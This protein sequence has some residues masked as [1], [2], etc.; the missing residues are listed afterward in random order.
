MR[1]MNQVQEMLRLKDAGKAIQ[2]VE[3]L[4]CLFNLMSK[5][6]GFLRSE[7]FRNVDNPDTL[8]VLHAWENLEA[9][10]T[11]QTSES[12]VAFSA[13]RPAAL[14]DFV[15]CGMNWTALGEDDDKGGRYLR[16]ELIRPATNAEPGPRRGEHVKASQTF[17]YADDDLPEYRGRI[18]R[19]TRQRDAERANANPDATIDELYESLLR[20]TAMQPEPAT[21]TV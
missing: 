9:W 15:P 7:V 19:L 13:S 1:G 5:Q 10:Q 2:A 12:K 21:A 17:T 4:S 11:F 20:T 3:R 8:L 14:Y 16:R 6:P 18:L